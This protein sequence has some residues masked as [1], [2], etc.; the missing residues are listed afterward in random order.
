MK[1][2][3]PTYRRFIFTII[4]IGLSKLVLSDGLLLPK[5]ENYPADFLRNRITEVYVKV[6]GL[7]AQTVVYH[8]FVNEWDHAVDA[9]YNFPVPADARTTQLLYTRNDTTFRAV[10]RVEPEDPNPGTGL[11]GLAEPGG[12][13]GMDSIDVG[14]GDDV[15]PV[16]AGGAVESGEGLLIEE[17]V[18]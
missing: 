18:D 4:L 1:T 5:D 13:D 8:E 15:I 14:L 10:L 3:I 11:G 9:V 16:G 17:A 6:D 2:Q 7:V 12:A